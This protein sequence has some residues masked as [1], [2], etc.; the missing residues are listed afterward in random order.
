MHESKVIDARHSSPEFV[1]QD[2][3]RKPA[4]LKR[5][6]GAD[7]TE[8]VFDSVIYFTNQQLLVVQSGFH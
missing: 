4:R 6:D 7:Q 3:I 5:E 2:R 1:T 8:I